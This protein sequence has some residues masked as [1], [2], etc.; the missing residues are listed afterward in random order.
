MD[1]IPSCLKPGHHL[2]RRKKTFANEALAVVLV[3]PAEAQ[4]RDRLGQEKPV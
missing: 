2:E 3:Q 4:F 1:S